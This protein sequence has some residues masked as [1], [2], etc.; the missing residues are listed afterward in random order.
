MKEL[1][2]DENGESAFMLLT[3]FTAAH[4]SWLSSESGETSR[5]W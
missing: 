3:V 5:P 4:Q 2:D 1:M